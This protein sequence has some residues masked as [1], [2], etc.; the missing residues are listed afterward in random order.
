MKGLGEVFIF[1]Y[2][3]YSNNYLKMGV[4]PAC[5]NEV[6]KIR[7]VSCTVYIKYASAKA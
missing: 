5:S 3:Q 7:T 1:S 6:N 2:V 4:E